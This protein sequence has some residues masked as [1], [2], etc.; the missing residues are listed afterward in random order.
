MW[1][2]T[3]MIREKGRGI[4]GRSGMGGVW[5]AYARL[6]SSIDLAFSIIV[7]AIR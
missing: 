1:I 5:K 7:V 2:N 3:M 6:L 4:D